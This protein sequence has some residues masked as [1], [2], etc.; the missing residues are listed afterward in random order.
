MGR[1]CRLFAQHV[2]VKAETEPIFSAQKRA[3]WLV[4]SD[5]RTKSIMTRRRTL[6]E[7]KISGGVNAC[8]SEYEAEHV[9]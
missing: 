3:A 5:L 2:Q 7:G 1:G 8:P 4:G 9:H 6:A